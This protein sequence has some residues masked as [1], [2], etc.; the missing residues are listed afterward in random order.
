MT[1]TSAI[2]ATD[3]PTHLVYEW[4][5]GSPIFYRN[6]QEVLSGKITSEEVMADS[7]LQA[8]IKSK[9]YLFLCGV[10]LEKG[11]EILVG[12]IGMQLA[13]KSTRAA[14]IAIFKAETF[15]L[16]NKY[17]E[18]APEIVIEIDVKADY[19]NSGKLIEYY[20]LKTQKLLAFGVKKVIWIFTD[21]ETVIVINPDQKLFLDWSD[22]VE[23]LPGFGFKLVDLLKR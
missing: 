6:Y 11:Y 21:S 2:L 19:P 12:E 10:L 8:W 3:V 20:E 17:T 4:D 1:G 14:D 23:V 9:L 22:E 13:P 7:T 18:Q 5:D 16:S 15:T